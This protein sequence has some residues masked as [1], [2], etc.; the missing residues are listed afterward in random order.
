MGNNVVLCN[1]QTSRQTSR[2]KGRLPGS[3]TERQSNLRQT[4]ARTARLQVTQR[5]FDSKADKHKN[6][7]A[8]RTPDSKL[9]IHTDS[10]LRWG[11][12]GQFPA[13]GPWSRSRYELGRLFRWTANP[14]QPAKR[15]PWR[16]QGRRGSN[17][18]R[19][20]FRCLWLHIHNKGKSTELNNT[21]IP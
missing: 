21:V 2:L 14:Q 10:H 4:Q 7:K 18:T 12:S 17:D 13:E 3:E 16:Q 15:L 20:Q 5:L 8:A 9:G 19:N 6:T 1:R 11:R